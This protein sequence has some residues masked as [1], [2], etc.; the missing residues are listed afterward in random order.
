[1]S[2]LVIKYSISSILMK[3]LILSNWLIL[4]IEENDRC[5]AVWSQS[6]QRV[7]EF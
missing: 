4:L 2:L 6:P 1:M 5:V 7:I 3:Q